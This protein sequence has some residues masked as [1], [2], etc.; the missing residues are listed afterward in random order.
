MARYMPSK[1]LNLFNNA[2]EVAHAGTLLYQ[3][4]TSVSRFFLGA[5]FL[6]IVFC[7]EI[8]TV[9]PKKQILNNKESHQ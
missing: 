1:S 9:F 5:I 7:M 3:I 4:W 6:I 2:M 8:K